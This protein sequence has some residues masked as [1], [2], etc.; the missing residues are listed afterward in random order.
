MKGY[1]SVVGGRTVLLVG[2]TATGKNNQEVQGN[3]NLITNHFRH[4]TG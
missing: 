4:K 1:K 3:F 2:G